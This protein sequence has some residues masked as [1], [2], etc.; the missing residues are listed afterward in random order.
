MS[1]EN[2]DN[3]A[4]EPEAL[5][6]VEPENAD[7]L[8]PAQ[9]ETVAEDDTPA[10]PKNSGFQKRINE[11][12]GEREDWKRQAQYFAEI[13]REKEVKQQP[14]AKA[15]DTPP[16]APKADDFDTYE[17]YIESLTDFKTDQKLAAREESQKQTEAN[18]RQT[19]AE[20]A[21]QQAMRDRIDTGREKYEDFDHVALNKA[22]PITQEMAFAVADSDVGAELAYYLGSN[23]DEASVIAGL[24]PNAQYR[25]IGKLE[26]K[27]ESSP[28]QA[29]EKSSA[30]API[31]PVSKTS[32]VANDPEKMS[33]D[34]WM[35]W[36]RKTG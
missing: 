30:P 27:L 11:L 3:E 28:V 12:V 36:R 13:A 17:E 20:T 25:A 6:A 7:N 1:E 19:D 8:E 10:K 5:E 34:E 33:V 16:I 24:S 31:K 15:A 29:T 32:T 21:Q 18:K 14:E 9:G 22:I 35:K 23:L 2:L 4:L 26:A